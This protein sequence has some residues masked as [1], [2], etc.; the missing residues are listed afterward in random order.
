MVMEKSSILVKRSSVSKRTSLSLANQSVFT[1]K[2][3]SAVAVQRNAA[4]DPTTVLQTSCSNAIRV[5]SAKLCDRNQPS[6]KST[7]RIESVQEIDLSVVGVGQDVRRSMEHPVRVLKYIVFDGNRTG[8]PWYGTR[9][10][11]GARPKTL[12]VQVLFRYFSGRS[13][14]GRLEVYKQ[15]RI[16]RNSRG[17]RI[18]NFSEPIYSLPRLYSSYGETTSKK[19]SVRKLLSLG[20][21]RYRSLNRQNMHK[22]IYIYT[23]IYILIT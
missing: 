12:L 15:S 2:D 8:T 3:R 4:S 14:I 21:G 19:K 22:K 16:F 20:I 13:I 10:T 23:Y 6:P 7:D 17:D 5:R 11:L 18:R 1:C 9:C